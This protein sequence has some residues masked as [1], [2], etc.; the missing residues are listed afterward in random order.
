MDLLCEC[1]IV[2]FGS[3]NV[4]QNDALIIVDMQNDFITGSLSVPNAETI[5]K[6]ICCLID[7]FSSKNATIIATKDY[8][9]KN[10]CSFIGYGGIFPKHCIQ[11]TTGSHIEKT[12]SEKLR[13]TNNVS[14]V[15]KGFS[16]DIDSYAAFQYHPNNIHVKRIAQNNHGCYCSI[17]WTGSFS[18]YSSTSD[19]DINAPPDI[20]SVLNKISLH[21]IL[22]NKKKIF[23][24]GLT[25]D[26]CVID[27]AINASLFG[28]EVYIFIDST[29]IIDTKNLQNVKEKMNEYNIAFVA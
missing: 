26:F 8:H 15:Y 4:D 11:N 5:I 9:P 3:F 18:L 7:K 27:T 21:D 28:F 6:P 23:I 25:L 2:S 19:I 17:S 12:I 1:K 10:H 22:V 14:V 20:M 29:M 16:P 24:C 13:Q